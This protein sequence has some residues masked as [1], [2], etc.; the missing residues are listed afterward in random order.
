MLALHVGDHFTSEVNRA[1]EVEFQS[2]LPLVESD[3]KKSFGGWSTGVGD[4]N[5]DAAELPRHGGDKSAHGGGVSDIESPGEGFNLVLLSDF[6][7]GGLERLLITSAHRDAA[8]F[9]GKGFGGGEAESLTGRGNQGDT[10]FQTQVH[11][12]RMGHYKRYEAPVEW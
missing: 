8:A 3:R 10:V 2:A 1:Q 7:G 11:R 12:V 5:V 9:G 6:V 4:A